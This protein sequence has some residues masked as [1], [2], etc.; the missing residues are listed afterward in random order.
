MTVRLLR[1]VLACAASLAVWP[2]QADT[3]PQ[4]RPVTAAACAAPDHS[5]NSAADRLERISQYEGLGE[6]CL[7]R[8]LVQCQAA[9]DRDL[10]DTATAHA[11]SIGYEALLRRGFGGNFQAMLAWWRSRPAADTL[12]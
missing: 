11:C 8:L 9:A 10:L 6:H 7:K 5:S 1:C 12:N 2:V 4:A 3:A